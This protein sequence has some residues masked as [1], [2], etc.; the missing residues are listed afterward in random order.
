MSEKCVS[1]AVDG[2]ADGLGVTEL[3]RWEVGVSSGMVTDD[4]KTFRLDNLK[5]VVIEGACGVPDRGGISKVG[6]NK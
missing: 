2:N 4:S 3:C 1:K 5:S 6:R